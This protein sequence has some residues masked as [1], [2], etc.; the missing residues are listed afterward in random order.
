MLKQVPDVISPDLMHVLM[1]MGH[2]DEICIG[3]G[4]FPGATC[5]KRLVRVNGVDVVPLLT[6]IMKFFPLD[7]YADESAMV[8][9]VVPGDPVVPEIWQ[10]YKRILQEDENFNGT[11]GE[12]PRADFYVRASQAFAVVMTSESALYANLILKKG[13]V[14]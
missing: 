7:P 6:A 9:G 4:N 13:V 14:T 3:D 2:G 10:D 11:L 12:L 1:S 5:A 8:M